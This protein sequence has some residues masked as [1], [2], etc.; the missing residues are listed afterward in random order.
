[1]MQSS[2]RAFVL[3]AFLWAIIGVT[4]TFLNQYDWIEVLTFEALELLLYTYLLITFR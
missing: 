3:Y 4:N 1:M 2:R